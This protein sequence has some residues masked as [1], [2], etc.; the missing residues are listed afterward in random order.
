[1]AGLPAGTVT[2]LFTDLEVSTRLWEHEPETMRPALARHD[3]I[4]RNAVAAHAAARVTTMPRIR[5]GVS[6][7]KPPSTS[8]STRPAAPATNG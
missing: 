8:R 5:F 3:S 2:F 6:T 1:V 7:S 4:L